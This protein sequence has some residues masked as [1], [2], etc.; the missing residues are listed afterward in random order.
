VF[1]LPRRFNLIDRRLEITV[2]N[3]LSMPRRPMEESNS[4]EVLLNDP[5]PDIQK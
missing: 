4:I 5:Q 3:M 1:L 2:E